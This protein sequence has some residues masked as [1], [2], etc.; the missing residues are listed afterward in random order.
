MRTWK[1]IF[2]KLNPTAKKAFKRFLKNDECGDFKTMYESALTVYKSTIR[3][4]IIKYLNSQRFDSDELLNIVDPLP[5]SKKAADSCAIYHN[6]ESWWDSR[7][8]E[9]VDDDW[10]YYNC[11][12]C[13]ED[14]TDC[15]CS[16]KFKN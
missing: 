5:V 14:L 10:L 12:E 2:K 6:Y 15:E 9:P 16:D 8:D 3:K 1:P 11:R 13:G 4:K 7:R